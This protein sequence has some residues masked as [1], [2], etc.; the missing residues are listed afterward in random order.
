MIKRVLN[1]I[2]CCLLLSAAAV[3]AAPVTGKVAVDGAGRAAV[4]VQ[5]YP[6]KSM[7]LSGDAPFTSKATGADGLFALDL[8]PGSYYL[9]AT[10]SGWFSYYGRNPVT[11]PADGL[12]D[13]NL[14]LVPAETP[15]PAMTTAMTT[16]VAGR[17]LHDGKPVAN[18]I[19]FVYPDLSAQFK[20]FGLGMSAPTDAKGQFEA[21]LP[22]GSYY[23]VARVRHGNSLAGPLQAGDLFG[24]LPGN[25][26]T[27]GKDGVT[28]VSLPVIAVPEKVSRHA[29]TM[30]G[31]TRISG[32]I[33]DRAGKPLTG[34]QALLYAD[35]TMLNRPLFVSQP[36]GEDGLFQL[37]FPTGGTFYLAARSNLGGTPAPGELYG[38]YQ[39][40]AGAA[41]KVETGQAI[42][43]LQIVVENVW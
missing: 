24:Y 42:E 32:R 7:A 20:G 33:V 34:L 5:A 9:L 14:P 1:L 40:S 26:V 19:V 21:P 2:I 22:A 29:A 38:R 12:A 18:A 35:D 27:V 16:G 31:Q 25:P 6:L 30:F 23:L 11:V 36:T 41:L 3:S 10:G 28:K 8:P 15:P 37:S 17:V 13:I 39:G 4:Q 43:D